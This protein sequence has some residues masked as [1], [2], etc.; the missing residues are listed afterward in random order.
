MVVLMY[1]RVSEPLCD[2]WGLCVTPEHFDQQMS[3]LREIAQ[4]VPLGHVAEPAVNGTVSIKA[5]AITFDDGYADNV[6][7]AKPILER[8]DIPATF[9]LVSQSVGGQTEFWWDELDRILLQPGCLPDSFT[10]EVD[11]TV[12][13]A[14]LGEAI[15]YS[16][17][18]YVQNRNWRAWEDPPTARHWLYYALWK[19]MRPMSSEGRQRILNT[20]RRWAGTDSQ[21]RTSHR[22]LNQMELSAVARDQLIEIGCHTMTHPQLS[23]LRPSLQLDEIRGCKEYLEDRLGHPVGSFAYP[24]GGREDYTTETVSLVREMGFSSACSTLPG[25]VT[26]DTDLFQLPRMPVDNWDGDRFAAT[27]LEWLGGS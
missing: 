18:S 26:K 12:M 23:S 25:L 4:V 19:Q 5:V 16:A 3:V 9:F 27:L 2:P 24:Y 7:A 15:A 10:L 1:H 21:P 22:A 20:L 14:E 8:H 11:G 13:R 6:H 17:E